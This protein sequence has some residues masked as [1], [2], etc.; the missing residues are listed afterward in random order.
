MARESENKSKLGLGDLF[1]HSSNG[2]TFLILSECS[3]FILPSKHD[4]S[5]GLYHIMLDS[6]MIKV[7]K[8]TKE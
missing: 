7:N 3:A 1:K 4:N 6:K 8:D 5:T 2:P